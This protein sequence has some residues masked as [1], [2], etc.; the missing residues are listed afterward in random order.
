MELSDGKSGAD[1]VR[2]CERAGIDV[3]E[4]G[5]RNEPSALDSLGLF[6]NLKLV[7]MNSQVW[8]RMQVYC[9]IQNSDPYQPSQIAAMR[10]P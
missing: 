2:L 1:T 8:E 6:R 3:G 9:R 4:S 7:G 10:L 5:W